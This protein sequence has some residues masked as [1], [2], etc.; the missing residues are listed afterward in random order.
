MNIFTKRAVTRRTTGLYSARATLTDFTLG[1]SLHQS[2][3][4]ELPRP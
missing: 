1:F 4:L 3:L 2:H